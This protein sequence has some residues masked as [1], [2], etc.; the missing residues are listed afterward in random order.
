LEKARLR[1]ENALASK[2]E[3]QVKRERA[4]LIPVVEVK[5]F[6]VQMLGTFRNKVRGIPASAS[7]RLEGRDGAERE[8]ILASFLDESLNDLADSIRELCRGASP[9]EAD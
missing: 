5:Q 4:E 1:K 6:C 9:A 2:Y 7:P 3:L 8:V